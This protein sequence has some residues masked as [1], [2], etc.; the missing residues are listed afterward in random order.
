M[1]REKDIY[2]IDAIEN[3]EAYFI[4]VNDLVYLF[5]NFPEMER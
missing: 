1:Q 4:N 5:D 2:Y 3:S